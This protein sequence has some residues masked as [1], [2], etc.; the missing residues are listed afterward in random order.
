MYFNNSQTCSASDSTYTGSEVMRVCGTLESPTARIKN[1]KVYTSETITV[2][3]LK[4]GQKFKLY[5]SGGSEV[6]TSGAAS[7][8]QATLS[9]SS[10]SSRPPYQK[11]AVTD[12]DG[13]TIK[14]T[15]DSGHSAYNDIWGGDTFEYKTTV[16]LATNPSDQGL[17]VRLDSGTWYTAP[18]TYDYTPYSGNHTIEAEA[19]REVVAGQKRY[20]WASWSDG[21]AISHSISWPTG[22]ATYT[23]NYTLQWYFDVVSAHDSP[24]GEGWYNNG[25]TASSSVTTPVTESGIIWECTGY[26]GTGSCPSGSSSSVSFTITAYSTCT[27]NWRAR[28]YLDR[29]VSVNVEKLVWLDRN[30]AVNVEKITWL[31]RNLSVNVEKTGWLDRTV[32]V[33]IAYP[34]WLDRAINVNVEPPT[35]FEDRNLVLNVEKISWMDRS[36]NVNVVEAGW[37]DRPLSVNVE[38]PAWL[39]RNISLNV[40]QFAWLDRNVSTNVEKTGWLDRPVNLNVELTNWLDRSII[41]NVEKITWKDWPL[42]VN[43]EKTAWL[44]R[45]LSVNVVYP[46]WLDRNI[47][48][49]VE[50][51]GWL[52]RNLLLNVEKTGWLDR[53]L[54]VYIVHPGYFD[55]AVSVNVEKTSW[56]D[57]AISVNVFTYSQSWLDRNVSVNV[58]RF[59]EPMLGTYHFPHPQSIDMTWRRLVARRDIVDR[60]KDYRVDLGGLGARASITGW[61]YGDNWETLRAEL[62]ALKDAAARLFKDGTGVKFSAIASDVAFERVVTDPVSG[63]KGVKYTIALYEV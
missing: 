13:S 33:N 17:Q 37:A 48:V 21:G 22:D 36:L 28:V 10:L 8:G 35:G 38:A 18:K 50:K 11:I 58:Q 1:I 62:E 60:S 63:R 23:A 43:V 26:T 15:M 27:W 54:Q 34:A 5:N 4:D 2:T 32:S 29:S 55:R 56:T 30:L 19:S 57:R 39:D 7:G 52:D 31:D 12:T 53:A 9:I 6:A 3:G 20:V 14:W 40:E 42:S 45:N 41:L 51:L 59:G 24:T 44:D 46:M 61:I 16:T 25:A 47:S 49:N